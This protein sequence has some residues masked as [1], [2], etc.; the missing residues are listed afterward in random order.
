MGFTAENLADL[1]AALVSGAA[2]LKL[3]TPTGMREIKWRSVDELRQII[4][5]VERELAGG[6]RTTVRYASMNTGIRRPHRGD[7]WRWW[8]HW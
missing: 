4:A 3:S 6:E 8:D 7:W 1:K 5:D 2:S